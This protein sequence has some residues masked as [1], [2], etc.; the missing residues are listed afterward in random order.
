MWILSIMRTPY[1]EGVYLGQLYRLWYNDT[2]TNEEIEHVIACIEIHG[3]PR[4]WDTYLCRK[5]F[6]NGYNSVPTNTQGKV[7]TMPNT[8]RKPTPAKS[9]Q[10]KGR[11]DKPATHVAPKTA[12]K[13]HPPYINY[14]TF[15]GNL[16]RDAEVSFTTTGKAIIKASVAVWLP[17]AARGDENT[18]WFDLVYWP[19]E[20]WTGTG[21]ET[22][23]ETADS[24]AAM[25]K[26]EHVVVEGS[27]TRREYQGKQYYGINLV[28]VQYNNVVE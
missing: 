21:G 19:H 7:T 3:K 24:F 28:K 15:S 9:Y 10:F 1:D 13:N 16:G 11:N 17:G 18:Q 4:S 8:N 5:G 14:S 27:M 2:L 26:G 12:P 23:D 22:V 20:D 6:R 25:E